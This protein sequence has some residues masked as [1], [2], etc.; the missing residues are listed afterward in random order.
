M[1]GLPIYTVNTNVKPLTENQVDAEKFTKQILIVGLGGIGSNLL[2]LVMPVISKSLHP[3]EIHLMDDDSVDR[4]NLVHQRFTESDIGLSKAETL[5][6]RLPKSDRVRLIPRI[7]KLTEPSQLVG[8]DLIIVAVDNDAPRKLVHRHGILWAD[9]RCQGDGWIIIDNETDISTI[10]KLP[11]QK[12]P[13][14]CQLPGAI[15]SGN[16]E[17][18]FAAVAAIGAQWLCQKLRMLRG[19]NTRS[20]GFAMGYLTHGQMKI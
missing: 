18:G 15:E 4:S 7:E 10:A 12:Q 1:E 5:V 8:Y 2:D 16:I 3:L 9:L 13:T 20:P 19:E 6:A 17:F 11:A 14:S